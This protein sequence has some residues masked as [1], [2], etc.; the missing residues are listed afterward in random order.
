MPY[1]CTLTV[2][3]D[4]VCMCALLQGQ[5][6]VDLAA[7]GN[8]L[9]IMEIVLNSE[10]GELLYWHTSKMFMTACERSRPDVVRCM[11]V[12]VPCNVLMLMVLCSVYSVTELFCMN[13]SWESVFP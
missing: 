9:R 11:L 2:R 3:S 13:Y 7:A 8:V 4:V 12:L 5:R 10:P 6:L 1:I